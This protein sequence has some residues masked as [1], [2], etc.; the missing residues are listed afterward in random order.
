MIQLHTVVVGVCILP[1]I[2]SKQSKI[3]LYS[4][5]NI[6]IVSCY[7]KRQIMKHIKVL[8]LTETDRLKLEKG[9]HK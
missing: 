6:Y 4:A 2:I 1:I 8:K 9:Y 5:Q 3:F 7:S